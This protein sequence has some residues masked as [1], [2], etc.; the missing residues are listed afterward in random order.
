VLR[1]I[2][3]TVR[4]RDAEAET[5]SNRPFAQD[6]RSGQRNGL[7][8]WLKEYEGLASVTSGVG[9]GLVDEPV[10]RH[11]CEAMGGHRSGI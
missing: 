11:G 9:K 8:T 5:M 10:I 7:P 1:E 3:V 4:A 2:V 6:D